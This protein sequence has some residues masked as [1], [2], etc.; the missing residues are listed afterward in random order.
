MAERVMLSSFIFELFENME[1]NSDPS[2]NVI[3]DFDIYGNHSTR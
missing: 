2:E 1:R 3:K